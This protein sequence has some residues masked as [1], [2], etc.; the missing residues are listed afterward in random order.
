MNKKVIRDRKKKKRQFT[1][2]AV[3]LNVC[4]QNHRASK[5]IKEK[6]SEMEGQIRKSTVMVTDFDPPLLVTD[7]A[8][9]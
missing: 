8:N 4:A 5:Y 3:I 2:K 1:K 6:L 7:R 9:R